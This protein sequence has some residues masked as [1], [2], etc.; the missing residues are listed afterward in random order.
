MSKFKKPDPRTL[1]RER[2]EK[3]QRIRELKLRVVR[4]V[5]SKIDHKILNLEKEKS[6]ELEQNKKELET[7]IYSV[8]HQ[9]GMPEDSARKFARE[10][11]DHILSFGILSDYVLDNSIT[12]IMVNQKDSI[13]IEERGQESL[14]MVNREFISN[15]HLARQLRRMVKM[16]GGKISQD[17]PIVDLSI[18]DGTWVTAVLP[19][20]AA[21]GPILTIQKSSGREINLDEL[22]EMQSMSRAIA[23]FLTACVAGKRN[24]IISGLTGSGRT[25]LLNSLIELCP[26]SE[27]ILLIED[28]SEIQLTHPNSCFLRPQSSPVRGHNDLSPKVLLQTAL[29]MRPDRIILGDCR[30]EETLELLQAMSSGYK[31]CLTTCHASSPADLIS[32]LETLVLLSNDTLAPKAIKNLIIS[33]IDLVVHIERMNDKSRRIT[34]ITELTGME[35]EIVTRSD[36]YRFR[37]LGTAESGKIDGIFEPTGIIPRFFQELQQMGISIPRDIF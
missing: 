26:L 9:L 29:R 6:P 19:P 3:A 32:R 24:I 7:M 30:G 34:H 21:L 33:S 27:R 2:R 35:G 5:I 8:I 31:G 13:F 20:V 25:T 10:M 37:N 4:K 15:A 36:I 11:L 17:H 28:R 14:T 18:E 1:I 16:Y 22:V 12:R 23:Q